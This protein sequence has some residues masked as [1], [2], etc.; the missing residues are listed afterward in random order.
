MFHENTAINEINT[1]HCLS[2][3]SRKKKSDRLLNCES[4]MITSGKIEFCYN[5]IGEVR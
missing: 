5:T 2:C 3:L 4:D 1:S